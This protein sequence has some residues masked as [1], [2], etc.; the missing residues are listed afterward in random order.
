MEQEKIPSDPNRIGIQCIPSVHQGD[1]TVCAIGIHPESGTWI[2][3]G[4]CNRGLLQHIFQRIFKALNGILRHFRFGGE[5]AADL[6][7]ILFFTPASGHLLGILH[8]D[9]MITP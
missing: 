3:G 7:H 8:I 5:K 6:C 1:L 2:L 9:Q 4:L